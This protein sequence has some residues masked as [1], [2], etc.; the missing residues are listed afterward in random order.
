MTSPTPWADSEAW[1]E[2][3]CHEADVRRAL[4]TGLAENQLRLLAI[5]ASE[6]ADRVL[7]ADIAFIDAVDMAYSAAVQC[8]LVNSVGDDIV[9]Q[10]LA[11]AFG[12]IPRKTAR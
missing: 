3:V 9:Q 11:T 2:L 12:K 4:R 1:F 7:C 10:V 5:R 6:L 8:G